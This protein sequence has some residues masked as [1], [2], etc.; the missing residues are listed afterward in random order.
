[1]SDAPSTASNEGLRVLVVDDNRTNRLVL[2]ALLQREGYDVLFAENGQQSIEVFEAESPDLILMDVMMPVMD[3]FEATQRI[4]AQAGELFVPIIIVTALTDEESLVKGISVGADDFLSKPYNQTIL[5]AK[6]EALMRTRAL[7]STQIRQKQELT[8]HQQ[9][10][11]EEQRVAKRMF[12]NIVHTGALEEAHI[13]FSISPMAIFNGDLLLAARTPSGALHVMLGDFT[14]HGL[15]ASIGAMPASE[16]FYG[17]T[18]KGFGIGDIVAELNKKLRSILPPGLFLAAAVMEINYATSSLTVWSGGLPDIYLYHP[19]RGVDYRI[20]SAHVPLGILSAEQFDRG[21][22]MREVDTDQY[23]FMYT[24]G[25]IEAENPAGEFFSQ[26]RLDT[27]F[28][29]SSLPMSPNMVSTIQRAMDD[30]SEGTEQDDDITMIQVACQEP[31]EN[32]AEG[33]YAVEH[34]SKAPAQWNFSFD[35]GPEVLRTLD[36]LPILV[37]VLMEVQGLYDHRERLY[38]VLT[39]LYSN[40]LEHGLLRLDSGMKATPDGFMNYY[41]ERES[42][43][44]ALEDGSISIRFRHTPDGNGGRLEL[45]MEDSGPGF[46]LKKPGK[47]LEENTGHS[48]RGIPLVTSLCESLEYNES[49]NRVMAVYCW[50]A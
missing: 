41:T 2:R 16:I 35:M 11:E 33:A 7:Y 30:F 3:G 23:L 31:E 50:E 39:E 40:A 14:G 47:S 49:G 24:D 6:I 8:Y 5:K 46:D 9:R 28:D 42:R 43:L 20:E 32:A 15:S 38:T 44:A 26:E 36:T 37:Q 27:Y 29:G 48:G 25:V 18:A 12:S 34:A 10:I 21:V 1:M 17:M 4:K 22:E 19:E 45:E 13:E